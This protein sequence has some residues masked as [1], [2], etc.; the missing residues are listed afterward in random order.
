MISV[1]MLTLQSLG[2]TEGKRR[3]VLDRVLH[4]RK[5]FFL[6]SEET[7]QPLGQTAMGQSVGCTCGR[8]SQALVLQRCNWGVIQALVLQCCNR[9]VSQALVLQCCNRGVSQALAWQCCNRGVS[10]ALVLQHC[11]WGVSRALVLQCCNWGVSR[12]LILQCCNRC[13]PGPSLAVL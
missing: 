2:C 8:V 4:S 13:E 11:N 12:A 5:F 1:K 6:H 3:S 7:G 9:G 10:R